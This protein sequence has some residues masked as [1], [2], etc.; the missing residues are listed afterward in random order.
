MRKHIVLIALT[1]LM[2]APAAR[3]QFDETNNLFYHTL[4][5]PQSNLLNPALFPTNNTFYIMLPGVDF[6]FGS[7]LSMNNIIYYDRTSEHTVI[8][9]NR[10]LSS[11]EKDNDFRL[12]ADVNLLGFGFKVGNTFINFNTRLVNHIGLGLPISTINALLEGNIG[13]D[14]MPRPVVEIVNGDILNATSYFEAGIGVA[15]RF[16]PINLTV[17][18]RAKYLYGVANVQTDNTKIVL[19]TDPAIDS[20]SASIYY[21]IQS[22]TFAP[23]DTTQK[24]FIFNAGDLL[25]LGQA[26]SGFSFDIGARYDLG[27]FTFSLAINDLSA[28]IHWKNNVTTWTPSGGQGVITFNGLNI[29]SMI[30]NGTFNTDSLTDYLREQLDGMTPHRVEDGDYWFAIPTKFNLGASYSFA[31]IFR[32]GFLFHGQLDR[33]LFCK[34]NSLAFGQ[35]VQNTFRWNTT[36][37]VGANLF[38]WVEVIAANSFVNDGSSF[39]VL[40]PGVGLVLTPATIFQ[41]YVMADYLSSFYLTDSKALNVKFGINLLFGKGSR[42]VIEETTQN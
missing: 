2:A 40:N 21:Q 3:A 4:R 39:D 6:Q 20:V 32:A 27:P 11:L 38:N 34:S 28:G 31:K 23:Y 9:L 13:D 12:G 33:G 22:A 35:E 17:G 25:K 37:S 41:V 8:D 16:E 18:L 36:L 42:T 14:N 30:D 24:K 26:N 7:P 5:T 1:V 29:N 15:H 19:N 10:I